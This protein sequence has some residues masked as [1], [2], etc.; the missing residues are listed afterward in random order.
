MTSLDCS[1]AWI[2][3]DLSKVRVPQFKLDGVVWPTE[4][5]R[6]ADPPIVI[7]S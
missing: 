7:L 1:Q 2:N 5:E 4:D 3:G 6:F